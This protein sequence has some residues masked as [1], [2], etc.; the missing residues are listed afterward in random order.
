MSTQ[1]TITDI[2]NVRARTAAT[3]AEPGMIAIQNVGGVLKQVDDQG[4]VSNLGGGLSPIADQT[5]LGNVSGV[6]AN[7]TALTAAQELTRLGLAPGG[8]GDTQVRLMSAQAAELTAFQIKHY[9]FTDQSIASIGGG[10]AAGTTEGGSIVQ[11]GAGTWGALTNTIF[12]TANTGSWA[13]AVR[14]ILP[15]PTSGKAAYITI[16]NGARSHLCGVVTDNSVSTTNYVLQAIGTGTTSQASTVA[17][18]ASFHDFVVVKSLAAANVR[19][20][21]DGVLAATMSSLA[22]VVDEADI[23]GINC[24]AGLTTTIT[25]LAYGFVRP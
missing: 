7:P 1:E 15:A 16:V 12:S 19:L 23:I 18:D 21:I 3:A 20:F 9:S 11:T 8:W 13:F 17:R 22:N 10:V 24:S 14:A 5:I 25:D 2:A 4:T 6:T